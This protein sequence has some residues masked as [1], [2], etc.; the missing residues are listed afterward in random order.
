M[1][2]RSP[3]PRPCS[4]RRGMSKAK[5]A[6]EQ[7]TNLQYWQ[8]Y[9]DPS[10]ILGDPHVPLPSTLMGVADR[11][12]A[13]L[14]LLGTLSDEQ[15][16]EKNHG[17]AVAGMAVGFAMKVLRHLG[18]GDDSPAPSPA[19]LKMAKL[20]LDNLL[21]TVEFYLEAWIASVEEI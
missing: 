2:Q 11:L 7:M 20:A 5:A 21:A 8:H 16:E 3:S 17:V 9:L 12:N 13:V 6:D 15:A 1:S 19:N 4:P 10:P 18:L 14:G